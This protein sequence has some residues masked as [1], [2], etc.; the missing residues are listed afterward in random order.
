MRCSPPAI[1]PADPASPRPV[2]PRQRYLTAAVEVL[3]ELVVDDDE[4][5]RLA[6]QRDTLGI[7]PTTAARICARIWSGAMRRFEEDGTIDEDE[8]RHI[9]AL[10]AGFDRLGWRPP[11]R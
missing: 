2:N 8:A 5:A 7:S 4:I 3:E 11:P 1:R 6:V 9:A 10:Q